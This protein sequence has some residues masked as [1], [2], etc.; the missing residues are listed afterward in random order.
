MRV[1]IE[2]YVTNDPD[3]IGVQLD[4]SVVESLVEK[5]IEQVEMLGLKPNR[6]LVTGISARIKGD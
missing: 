6:L 2:L 3:E 5:A 4:S 1:I